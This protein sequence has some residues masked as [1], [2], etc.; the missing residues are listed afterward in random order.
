MKECEAMGICKEIYR[1]WHRA[2]KNIG[3]KESY[4]SPIKLLIV[5]NWFIEHLFCINFEQ[6]FGYFLVVK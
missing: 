6:I 2:S 3:L 1:Q 5:G 4:A